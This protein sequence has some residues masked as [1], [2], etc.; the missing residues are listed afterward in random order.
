MSLTYNFELHMTSLTAHH[1][2]LLMHTLQTGSLY[3]FD[4]QAESNFGKVL[5]M[6]ADME[7]HSSSL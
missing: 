5:M 1:D 7:I 4:N 3:K 2:I 6:F